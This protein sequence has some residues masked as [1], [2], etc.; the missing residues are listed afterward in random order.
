MLRMTT[1]TIREFG[2]RE[3]LT[4]VDLGA[5]PCEWSNPLS[6]DCWDGSDIEVNTCQPDQEEC[7]GWKWFM[8]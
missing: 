7:E 5:D 8:P 2:S 1:T 6:Q 4:H 3:V